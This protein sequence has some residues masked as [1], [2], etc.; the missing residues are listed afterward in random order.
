MAAGRVDSTT[1]AN[2]NATA[3]GYD[4]AG[5]RTN[6]TDALNHV[7][8]L[9]LRRGGQSDLDDGRQRAHHAVSVRRGQPAHQGHLSGLHANDTDYDAL[10]RTTTKT[11]Q[12][13]KV[14]AIPVRQAGRLV[15]VTDALG[16]A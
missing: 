2:S 6:V 13:G 14:Y 3:Y 8:G 12:A 4:D 16:P 5:R 11:D 10:G 15:Q 1:D 7:T 9:H